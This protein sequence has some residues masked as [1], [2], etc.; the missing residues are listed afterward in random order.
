MINR[1]LEMTFAAAIKEAKQR[2]HEF[3][4]LEHI[5]YAIVH[6]VTGRR[7]LYHCGADLDDLKVR[8]EK[9]LAERI[10]TL[11]DGTDQDPV[12]TMSVQRVIQRAIMHVHGAEKKEIEQEAKK[13]DMERDINKAKDPYFD[14]A[15]VML[16][17]AI[18]MASISIIS[19]SRPVFYFA[20][21]AASAGAFLTLN[22]FLMFIRFPFF[23]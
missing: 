3:F 23:H 21:V 6:D 12:Q 14:Y 18:V 22:G 2:R 19:L 13:L 10:E 1:E 4:T 20:I 11:P 8:L 16:Q 7:I 5:L 17:I 15:E 9:F